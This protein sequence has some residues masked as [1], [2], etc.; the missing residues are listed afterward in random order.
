MQAELGVAVALEAKGRRRA[1][2]AVDA[3]HAQAAAEWLAARGHVAWVQER[4]RAHLL[5]TWATKSLQATNSS[6]AAVHARG[7]TGVGQTVGIA[8]TGVDFDSCF[9][10][11]PEQSVAYCADGGDGSAPGCANAQHR[12]ITSYRAWEETFEGNVPDYAG[13]HGTHVAGSVAGE[14]LPSEPNAEYAGKHNGAAPGAKIAFD[15]IGDLGGELWVPW[16]LAEDLFPHSYNRGARIHSNSWGSDDYGYDT[17]AFD[18]DEFS[19]DNDDFLIL[20][21]AG[22]AGDYGEMTVGTPATA[23]NVIAVGATYNTAEAML[24]D[25][26][27]VTANGWE[28]AALPSLFGPAWPDAL[29]TGELVITDP[30]DLCSEPFSGSY[31]NKVA[32]I[33]RG[34]C[35][36]SDKVYA[37]QQA[38]ADAVI[39]FN[40][41]GGEF[42]MAGGENADLVT[43]PSVM[44]GL[45][46]G[47]ALE[48]DIEAAGGVLNIQVGAPSP[49]SSIFD[50]LIGDGMLASYSSWGQTG[51]MRIK[52]DVLCVGD[53]VLSARSD[54]DPSSNNCGK[55]V[56]T[57]DGALE[58]MSGTSMATPICAGGAALVRQY[59]MDG[60]E[61]SATPSAPG[62]AG[63]KPSAALVKATMIHA[64]VATSYV[65]IYTG[66]TV[67]PR[68]FNI[69]TGY[70]RVALD[71]VLAF[72]DAPD[73]FALV[74]KDREVLQPG[75]VRTYCFSVA[76]GAARPARFS[77]VWTDTPSSLSS[78][79]LLNQDLDLLVESEAGEFHLGN[80]PQFSDE[81][82]RRTVRDR[83][84]NTEQVTVPSA[85][86]LLAVKV[87]AHGLPEG[88]QSYALVATGAGLAE[89]SPE[90]CAWSG[91]PGGCSGHGTC[92]VGWCECHVGFSGPDCA[93]PHAVLPRDEEYTIELS[94]GGFSTYQFDI[95]TS[96]PSPRTDR[97][98]LVPPPVLSGH[99]SSL[100]PY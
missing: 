12:K 28:Y 63:R 32:L 94:P 74:A 8:D 50:S 76:A 22:N 62:G 15:D 53:S 24:R 95:H 83:M 7:I 100:P 68:D 29:F 55:V 98:R 21:A 59:Y 38:G 41:E 9:F 3:Q 10:H 99:G 71:S 5:N 6:W 49:D 97:K 47:R 87:I 77:L 81:T 66:A 39:V 19:H 31:G 90:Q 11:D 69:Q 36:F 23:K 4:R 18:C 37:A 80:N 56:G 33:S 75:D 46:A 51:D 43:I 40:D 73:G 60:Y 52:P 92:H 70:G 88:A 84:H 79:N 42:L 48:A 64:G 35:D 25:A 78:M 45:A 61:N 65:D 13:G 30:P 58:L 34:T 89:L 2:V 93:R 20:V 91:C 44:V 85:E 96:R 17:M 16:D 72:G 86:G 14:V 1:R 26:K 27:V 82:G 57:G 67:T 54:G